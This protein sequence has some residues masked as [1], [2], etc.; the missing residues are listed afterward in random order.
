MGGGDDDKFA[1]NWRRDGPLPDLPSSRDA[2]R[3]RFDGPPSREPPPAT[4]ADSASDWRS[5]RAPPRSSPSSAPPPPEADQGPSFKRRGS[6]LRQEGAPVGPADTEDTWT[7]GSRFK[8][9]P[10]S[11]PGSRFGSVRGRPDMGPPK[12]TP[13]P[14]EES[15]WRRPRAISRNSTSR[16][17]SVLSTSL[18]IFA[19][20]VYFVATSSTPPTPQLTRRKLEL[21]PKST[22]G[23]AVS[24]PLS[25]PNPANSSNSSRSN[26]FGAAK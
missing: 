25:S 22:S 2:S 1:S 8:P 9:A 17:F 11:E 4:V 3:R 24:S 7:M 21:L 26:P 23:S 5:S 14:P 16:M 10:P 15:D 18:D 20:V 13:S 19:H 6:G 12:E